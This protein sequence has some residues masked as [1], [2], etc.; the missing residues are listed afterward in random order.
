[1]LTSVPF[2]LKIPCNT[3]VVF[4]HRLKTHPFY[5]EGLRLRKFL[6]PQ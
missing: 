2:F 1:M 3:E 6:L 4:W 5:S